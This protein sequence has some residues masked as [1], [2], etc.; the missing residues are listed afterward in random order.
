M[1]ERTGGGGCRQCE[2]WRPGCLL[3]GPS[4]CPSLC[5]ELGG[6]DTQ[7]SFSRTEWLCCLST[8]RPSV[9]LL[10]ELDPSSGTGWRQG[11]PPGQH[12]PSPSASPYTWPLSAG[13]A[14]SQLSQSATKFC[15]SPSS[16]QLQLTSPRTLEILLQLQ[17]CYCIP[18]FPRS[19]LLKC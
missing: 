17:R 8:Q 16:P 4:G 19:S 3:N 10:W 1:P 5:S 6:Q 14:P 11:W 9:Y 15:P 2:D 18:F 13:P 7:A 12:E